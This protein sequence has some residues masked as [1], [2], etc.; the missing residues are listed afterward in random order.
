MLTNHRKRNIVTPNITNCDVITVRELARLAVRAVTG[1]GG[2]LAILGP[3]TA[4]AQLVILR[5]QRRPGL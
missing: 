1:A 3:K 4:R 2:L 5:P